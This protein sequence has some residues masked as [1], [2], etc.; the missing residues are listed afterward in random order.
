MFTCVKPWTKNNKQNS[1]ILRYY[2]F[3]VTVGSLY[4]EKSLISFP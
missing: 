1:K 2:I 4:L 3:S